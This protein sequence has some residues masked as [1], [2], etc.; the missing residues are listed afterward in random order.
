VE[1]NHTTDPTLSPWLNFDELTY[2]GK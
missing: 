2:D 1:S